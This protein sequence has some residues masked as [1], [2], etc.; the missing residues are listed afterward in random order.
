MFRLLMIP[1]MGIARIQIVRFRITP[2]Q[3][4]L[5]AMTKVNE[6]DKL[7]LGTILAQ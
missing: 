3:G 4:L 2:T 7:T 5:V 6:T 1:Q